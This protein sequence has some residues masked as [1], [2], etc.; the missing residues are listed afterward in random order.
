ML[1][2]TTGRGRMEPTVVPDAVQ[3]EKYLRWLTSLRDIS[4]KVQCDANYVV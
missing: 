1:V 3:K 2:L 4:I